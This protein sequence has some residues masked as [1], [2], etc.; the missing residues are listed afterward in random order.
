M[1]Q[2]YP[3]EYIYHHN[4]LRHDQHVIVPGTVI[5]ASAARNSLFITISV[6]ATQPQPSQTSAQATSSRPLQLTNHTL[7]EDDE[8]DPEIS[9]S[10]PDSESESDLL[11]NEHGRTVVPEEASTTASDT[12][13]WEQLP[14]PAGQGPQTVHVKKF[15]HRRALYAEANKY[16]VGL[17]VVLQGRVTRA[18][19]AGLLLL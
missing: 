13:P 19:K 11:L 6:D 4:Q 12:P 8:S 7:S 18:S 9:P 15:V 1:L 2:C 14:T 17:Q 3:K 5:K 10:F 16:P